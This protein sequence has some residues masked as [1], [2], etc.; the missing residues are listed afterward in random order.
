MIEIELNVVDVEDLDLKE[1]MFEVV[2]FEENGI[3]ENINYVEKVG[4]GLNIFIV[5]D[6]EEKDILVMKVQN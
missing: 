1:E 6:F 2:V 3:E 4:K 5:V